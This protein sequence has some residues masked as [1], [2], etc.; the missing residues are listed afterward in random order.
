MSNERLTRDQ[1]RE[2]ARAKAKAM[3]EAEKKSQGR[4]KIAVIVS[5][6]LGVS[7]IALFVG[8][9]V[10]NVQSEN[11]T[12]V[13]GS[14]KNAIFND[15]VR[16][17]KD[18]KVITSKDQV[19]PAIHNIIIWQ[20]PQ[21]VACHNFEVPNMPKIRELVKS[22]QYTLEI[23]PISFMDGYS[24][25]NYSSRAASALM[26]VAADSPDQFFDYNEAQYNN[27]PEEGTAGP[28]SDQLAELAKS[29][30]VTNS[31]ALSCIK[32]DTWAKWAISKAPDGNTVVPGT[33]AKFTGTPFIY[34]NGKQLGGTPNPDEFLQMLQ[35]A[36]PIT[37]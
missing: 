18:L 23:H 34:V 11:Q 26:C 15:G 22:G 7:V 32:K 37:K 28:T 25:N 16:I 4:K 2:A 24:Q 29:V 10:Q 27:W 35:Q 3:R 14:P 36:A 8:M 17:G 5:W 12:P 9:A 6:I 31:D 20:D 30:G 13:V 1:Q 21:C 19:D 33:D